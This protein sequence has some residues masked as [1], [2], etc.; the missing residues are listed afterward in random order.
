MANRELRGRTQPDI[1]LDRTTEQSDA[2][3]IPKLERAATI[4]K[5]ILDIGGISN[6]ISVI[7]NA[8]FLLPGGQLFIW[9]LGPSGILIFVYLTHPFTILPQ[10]VWSFSLQ[11]EKLLTFSTCVSVAL[12]TVLPLITTFYNNNA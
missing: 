7:L 11:W 5:S 2:A 4:V 9:I 6:V 12:Q 8:V 3:P 1:P 10:Q